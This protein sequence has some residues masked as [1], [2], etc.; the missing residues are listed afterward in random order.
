MNL[1][2]A[3][4]LPVNFCISLMVFGDSSSIIALICSRLP[5]YQAPERVEFVNQE[6]NKMLKMD[7][8]RDVMYPKWL[9]S[10]FS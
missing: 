8:V 3:A 4:T 2:K 5:L 9:E 6:V 7:L 1:F 10:S